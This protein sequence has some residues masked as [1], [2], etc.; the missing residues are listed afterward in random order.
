MKRRLV[1]RPA[2]LLALIAWITLIVADCSYGF[3][4]PCGRRISGGLRDDAGHSMQVITTSSNI[5]MC[6][7][8]CLEGDACLCVGE[9]PACDVSVLLLCL[10]G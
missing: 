6:S 3:V 7:F 9:R 4:L 2:S 5:C 10:I 1:E 8:N